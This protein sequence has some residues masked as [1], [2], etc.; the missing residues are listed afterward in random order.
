MVEI[1]ILGKKYSYNAYKNNLYYDLM[2]LRLMRNP[3]FKRVFKR[4]VTNSFISD[5]KDIINPK[6]HH[7][8]NSIWSMSGLSGSGKSTAIM[9]ILKII[10]PER[11]SYKNFCF[12]DEQ[13]LQMAKALPRDSFVV[14][15][16][17]TDK[18]VYGVGSNR[19]S[20]SLQ[21]LAET[22]RKRGLSLCFIEPEE[23]IIDIAKWYLETVD[24]DIENRITRVALKEPK[25]MEYLGAIYIPILPENDIDIIK[26]GLKKDQFM[27]DVGEGKLSGAKM[28]PKDI[29]MEI[30]DKINFDV[31]RTKKERKAFVIGEFPHYTSG[32]IELIGTFLEIIHRQNGE[33]V[34]N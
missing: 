11:F 9:S 28:N 25:T 6:F 22:S 15:D 8:D 26:Y 1:D 33:K 21:L 10:I 23:K 18:G 34:E 7:E 5:M 13:I 17:G 29:A 16:E 31:Y 27:K 4:D 14:R 20:S 19:Q 3:S 12:Y 32:E 30:Y 2:Q 24:M